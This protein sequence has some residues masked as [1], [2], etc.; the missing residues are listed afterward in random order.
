MGFSIISLIH[1]VTASKD[2]KVHGLFFG[3][4]ILLDLCCV[5]QFNWG[6]LTSFPFSK[7]LVFNRQVHFLVT[8]KIMCRVILIWLC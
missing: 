8:L 6:W 1:S 5:T 4:S 3:S 2:S 7:L